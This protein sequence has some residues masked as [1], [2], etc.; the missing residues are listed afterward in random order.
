MEGNRDDFFRAPGV[1]YKAD[2][3]FLRGC[4]RL[5]LDHRQNTINTLQPALYGP[6]FFM[7]GNYA[8]LFLCQKQENAVKRI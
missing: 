6:V 7:P 1:I 3:Y 4:S 2:P 5:G 8:G